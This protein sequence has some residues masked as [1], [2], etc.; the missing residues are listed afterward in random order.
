M[1]SEEVERVPLKSLTI[2]FMLALGMIFVVPNSLLKLLGFSLFF[3]FIHRFGLYCCR[4]LSITA[5]LIGVIHICCGKLTILSWCLLF[6]GSVIIYVA[7]IPKSLCFQVL[8]CFFP[9]KIAYWGLYFFHV[10]HYTITQLQYHY[11]QAKEFSVSSFY[12]HFFRYLALSYQTS[13]VIAQKLQ[14]VYCHRFFGYR[15]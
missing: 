10:F 15:P 2:S 13:L 8:G 1:Y 6:I 14:Q 5:I 3:L 12:L 4:V 9:Q 7:N 11:Q